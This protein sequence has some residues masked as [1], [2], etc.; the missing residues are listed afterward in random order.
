M[1][2]DNKEL[3]SKLRELEQEL[4]KKLDVHETAIIGV[5]QRI[6]QLIDPPPQPEPPPKEKIGFKVGEPKVKYRTLR[7]R[8]KSER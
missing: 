8:V 3:A 1:L 6:M 7:V 2:S 5:L 4:K